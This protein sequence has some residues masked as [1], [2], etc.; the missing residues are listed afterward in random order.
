MPRRRGLSLLTLALLLSAALG[1]PSL[2]Q[3]T[4]LIRQARVFDGERLLGSRD[5]LVRDGRIARIAPSIAAPAG[6]TVVQGANRTLLPGLIDA[7]THS[8]G[9]AL[10]QALTFGVTTS[11]DM[12][13]SVGEAAAR[14]A[15]QKAGNVASR[16][17]LFSS[18][19]LVT[20]PG[21]HGT[22][23]GIPIPT[24]SAP[25]S[26]QAFVDAL[27]TQGSDYVKIVIDDGTAYGPR[28]IP[29]LSPATVAAV[30]RAAHA[31]GK[32]A[33]VHV[34]TLADAHVAIDAGADGLVHLFTD[35]A[36]DAGF[37]RYVAAHKAFVVPTLTVLRSVVGIPG[38]TELSKDARLAPWLSPA[39]SGTLLASFPFK[40]ARDISGAELAVRELKAAGVPLLA[41]TDAPNPGTAHGIS[42]HQE[43]ENLVHAGLT[44]TEALAAATGTPARIFRLADRGRIE[45]G[46]RADLLLVDGDPTRDITATRAIVGIWKGGVPLDRET[47]GTRIAA[48]R[49]AAGAAPKLGLVSDFEDGKATTTFGAGWFI[50][51]DAFAGGKSTARMSV[52]DGGANGSAKSLDVEGQIAPGLA[53]AWG[54]VMFMP[55]SRPMAPAD[56]S[57]AK[58]IRF[59]ARGDGRTY[60]VMVFAESKGHMPLMQDFVA[61]AEWKE[62]VFPIASFGG[63]DGHDITGIAIT[64]GPDAGTFAVRLDDVRVQ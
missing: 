43:M 57:K 31:R 39:A 20:A 62:L 21:G 3:T 6:A 56:L 11:L 22:E 49:A 30:A 34:G 14:R 63:I 4:T 45:V 12:F 55:A 35:R 26:A 61:G 25:E 10:E 18:G 41:G 19:T 47:I 54:G 13:T 23:Y 48:Q 17:D 52:M 44:P 53:F 1:P 37:G 24:I 5:V 27:V 7:H 36:P 38:G 42:M 2:A 64:A 59:W 51:T 40:G 29:T 58:E 32:L 9:D 16:A 60:K 50:S 8:Y 33:V 15:E 28:R 46:R